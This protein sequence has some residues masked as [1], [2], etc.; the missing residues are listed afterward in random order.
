M[1]ALSPLSPRLKK[2]AR[3]EH[4]LDRH[5]VVVSFPLCVAPG[6]GGLGNSIGNS[7]LL[8]GDE[9]AS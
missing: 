6:F 7:G 4:K 3:D 2:A 8:S 5:V 9:I 1:R